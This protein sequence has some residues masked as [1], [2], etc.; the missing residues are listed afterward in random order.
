[1]TAVLELK[2]LSVKYRTSA[3][4]LTALRD[5]NL[6]VN[7]GE[8]VGIVGESGCGKSTVAAAM[9]KILPPNGFISGGEVLFKG[10]DLLK[11]PADRMRN[12]R[13]T[14][15][16]MI[17]QDPM[18]S[19]N[20]VFSIETQMLDILRSHIQSQNGHSQSDVE[21]SK[22]A[23]SMLD[24][25][26][27][28]DAAERIKNYPHQFSGGMR[29]RIFIAMALMA[30]PS[31]LIADEPT[32]ALDVTLEAQIMELIRGLRDEFG[33]SILYISH[34]LGVIAQLCDQVVVMYAGNIVE[35]GD[36]FRIFDNPTHPY[37]RALLAAYPSHRQ[38][39]KRLLAIPGKVPSLK[40]LPA[41]CKFADRCGLARPMCFISEPGRL[42]V[43]E[44]HQVFCNYPPEEGANGTVDLAMGVSVAQKPS[45]RQESRRKLPENE[46]LISVQG[47]KTY[48]GDRVSLFNQLLSPIHKVKRG[49][50]RAVDGVDLEIRYGE[51]I[52]LVGE[53]GSGKTTL[54]KTILHLIKSTNGKIVFDGQDITHSPENIIRPLRTRMQMIYQD[55][56]S[57]L[58]PRMKVSDLLVEPFKIQGVA[59]NQKKEV[60]RLLDMVGLST[61]QADKYPHELSGGQA[62]RI[63]IARALALDRKSVV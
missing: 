1:M 17:F 3:G 12:L 22:T 50:V 48:F 16:A 13:G 35:S 33:T 57:S 26:G 11:L 10:Q 41:G 8:I 59:Y 32:S 40:D 28:P 58:S 30:N 6:T 31:L 55:P 63:G 38:R 44:G 49:Y 25:V 2:N 56:Y 42:L 21:L 5:I 37:T 29:Q 36:T 19:L 54:G 46:V 52:G 43:A 23:I 39:R 62:R 4:I 15:L 18:T 61:E 7:P 51:T 24:R 60:A 45:Q 14:Q 20:P 47:L 34:D 27:I 53:S 9:M